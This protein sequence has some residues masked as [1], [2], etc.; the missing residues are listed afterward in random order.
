M[1]LLM[2]F[3]AAFVGFAI[4]TEDPDAYLQGVGEIDLLNKEFDRG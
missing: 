1:G 2:K 4:G 3:F